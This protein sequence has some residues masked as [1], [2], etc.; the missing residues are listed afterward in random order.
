MI[1]AF[2]GYELDTDLFELRR[3]GQPQRVEPQVFD[4]LSYLVQ[5]A[6]RV[7]TKQELLDTVWPDGFVSEATLSSRITAARKAIGDSG[8]E[9]RLIRTVHGRGFR[10]VGDVTTLNGRAAS[11]DSSTSP[12]GASHAAATAKH[13][14]TIRF[15][16]TRDGVR[17]AYASVGEGPP[18]VKAPNWL[19]H[20]EYEWESPAWRH[21]WEDLARDHRVVRF[22]QR[23]SGL[24]DRSVDDLS[25]E[26]WVLDLETVVEAAGVER[27]A[28]LGISQ[29][30]AVAV[31]Y[32][33][34]H[35]EKVSKLILC[36]AYPRGW[37]KRGQSTVEHEAVL[38]LIREGWGRDNPVYRQLFTATFMP[39]ATPEQVAW[40]NELQRMSTSA[41]NAVRI[42]TATGQIDILDRLQLVKAP[43]LVLH[44]RGDERIPFSEGRQMASLIPNARFVALESRNHL[45]LADEPAWQTLIAEVRAFLAEGEDGTKSHSRRA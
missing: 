11:Q 32:A 27:F 17:L 6:D 38:T 2:D 12:P 8:R 1:H 36:G 4:V 31:E 28:L 43:T 23:G 35:P 13:Q 16:T 22:D 45:T 39:E 20:L 30:G 44:A 41:E 14:Q 19:T 24:S 9:Q 25:F 29:G 7:V 40:F 15:C 33:V 21:W 26:A 37:A 18:I 42:R 10:F 5:H 3:N 34:R